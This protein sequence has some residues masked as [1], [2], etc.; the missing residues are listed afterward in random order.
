MTC[1]KCGLELGVK[2]RTGDGRVILVCRNPK[3]GVYQKVIKT[4]P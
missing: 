2:E 4:I 3:C 1:P